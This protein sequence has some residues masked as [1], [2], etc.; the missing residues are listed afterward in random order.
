MERRDFFRLTIT[1]ATASKFFK[2]EAS[3]EDVR[4][5]AEKIRESVKQHETEAGAPVQHFVSYFE[6][7]HGFVLYDSVL[8]TPTFVNPI[9]FFSVPLGMRINTGDVSRLKSDYDTNCWLQNILPAPQR[10]MLRHLYLLFFDES[11]FLPSWHPVW[12]NSHVRLVLSLKDYASGP[13]FMF[14]HPVAILSSL[15]YS[16]IGARDRRELSRLIGSHTREFKDLAIEQGELF[17][18]YLAMKNPPEKEITAMAMLEGTLAR[19]VM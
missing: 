12:V 17:N 18:V 2:G 8:L 7:L 5:E 13:A 11:G 6:L 19:G 16:K 3:Q 15:D 9:N 1:G 4:R 14:M 10:M